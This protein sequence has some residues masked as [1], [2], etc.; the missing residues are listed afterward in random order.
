MMHISTVSAKQDRALFRLQSGIVNMNNTCKGQETSQSTFT[1]TPDVGQRQGCNMISKF[2]SS[3]YLE[4]FS[5]TTGTMV[6]C[7]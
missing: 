3:S 4:N 5:R 6:G 1:P 2:S 7:V